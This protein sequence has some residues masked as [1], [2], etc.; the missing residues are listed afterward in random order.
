MNFVAV[1]LAGGQSTRMG[2]DKAWLEVEGRPLLARQIQVAR[3]AGA[4]EVFLSGRA[5][6][7]YARFGCRVVMDRRPEAGPL[8]G[9][10][11]A[12]SAATL[13]LLLALAV[14]MPRMCADLL[15]QIAA[16]CAGAAGAIP[17]VKGAIEPLAAFYPKAALPL[18]ADLLS[19]SCDRK[20]GAKASSAR[21]LAEQCVARD[22][23]C[24]VD[25]SPEHARAFTNWNSPAD[26]PCVL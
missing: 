14:D 4:R 18:V 3:D 24:F 5:G 7:D 20:S 6:V 2:R 8:A 19:H 13:P 12:L 10:E 11:S 21:A 25:V 9:I 17:R 23:A 16:R 22:L 1:I 15:R 26:V